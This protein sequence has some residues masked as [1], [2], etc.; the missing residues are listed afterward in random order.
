MRPTFRFPAALLT[1]LVCLAVPALAAAGEP[2]V[3]RLERRDRDVVL[4]DRDRAIV[5]GAGRR[6]FLGVHVVEL[7]PELRRHFRAAE[8]AGVLV[9]KVEANSPAAAAGIAVGDVLVAVDGEEVGSSF[10]LRRIVGPREEG[11]TVA[12][13][14]VRDGR[15]L[16][17]SS[18]LEERQGRMLELGRLMQRDAEGRP[19]L[20]LPAEQDWEEFAEGFERFGE[21][22]GEHIG[23]AM[24]EALE[25]PDVR[26]RIGREL[27]QREQL[28][29]QIE[30][31]ER[32]L[33]D[34]ERKLEEQ[35]R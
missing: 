21:H 34:L 20:V 2:T 19:L 26:L 6:G 9:S 31:L 24:E 13:D 8:D 1:A 17:V 15:R 25:D 10:D 23:E 18:R 35:R 33:Q 32:R 14:L 3:R 12:I 29:R 7:T 28:E 16:S 4:A 27:R 5:L 22:F 11:E 30:V